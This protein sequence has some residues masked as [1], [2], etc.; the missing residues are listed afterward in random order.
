M[1]QST[2]E[3]LIWSL[4]L[5]IDRHPSVEGAVLSSQIFNKL[6]RA[7]QLLLSSHHLEV[8]N[9][10]TLGV[11]PSFTR[12][13]VLWARSGEACRGLIASSSFQIYGSQ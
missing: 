10:F 8:L 6:E 5:D 1:Y 11:S 2:L 12:S 4:L 3:F 13:M 7:Y 9:Y